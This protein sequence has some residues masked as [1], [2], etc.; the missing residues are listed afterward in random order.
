MFIVLTA[1]N[2]TEA[3]IKRVR[4]R[5]FCGAPGKKDGSR[6]TDRGGT[7]E[8]RGGT[9]GR[10]RGTGEQRGLIGIFGNGTRTQKNILLT[11]AVP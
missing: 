1:I 2:M 8:D 6:G 7:G 10:Q 11:H 5:T 3:Q 4:I 9:G